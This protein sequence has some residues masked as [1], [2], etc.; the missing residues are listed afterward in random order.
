MSRRIVSRPHRLADATRCR[1]RARREADSFRTDRSVREARPASGSTSEPRRSDGAWWAVA[2]G[3]ALLAA[4]QWLHAPSVE[5]LVPLVVATVAALG[6]AFLVRG[7]QR[8]W[9]IG[10]RRCRSPSPRCSRAA[11]AAQLWRVAA[12]LGRLAARRGRSRPRRA[13]RRARRRRVGVDRAARRRAARAGRSRHGVRCARQ[14]RRRAATNAAS[15][16]YR[17]DS[18]VRVG[19]HDPPA[20]RPRARRHERRRDAVLSRAAGRRHDATSVARGR[21]DAARRRSAGA[22]GLSSPLANRIAA[23]AGFSGFS[24]EPPTDSA[25]R[26]AKCCTTRRR[27]AA[28]RRSRGVR[29]CRAKSRSASPSACAPAPASRSSS[30]SRCFII[31]VW[32]GTRTL[33]QRV[34]A[35]AVGLACTALV[36][37][38]QYSNL[39]R[40]FDP[41]IYFTP[42]GRT[43]HRATPARSRRRARLVLLGILAVFRRRAQRAVALDG[44]RDDPARRR[45]SVRFCCASSRAACRSR[46]TAS[47]RR[48]G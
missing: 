38:N 42:N 5:Y 44:G 25:E 35:L 9:A 47:T 12:R 36:P 19:R 41:A 3:A 30:R 26:A 37:L 17:G 4:S 21:R 48:S 43:A 40:L 2:A 31:G 1:R 29:S 7:A 24:F 8:W 39:T 46:R 28:V 16:V 32:R 22:T 11:G 6:A 33:S 18:A 15:C 45:R 23:T 14:A 34:G 10:V 27:P 13:S 20:G